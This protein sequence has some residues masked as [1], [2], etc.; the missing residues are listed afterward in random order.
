MINRENALLHEWIGLRARIMK[1]SCR[2]REG[3]M[4]IIVDE[5]RNTLAIEGPDGVVRT[6]PKKSCVFELETGDGPV[7]IM[8][9]EVCYAPEDRPKKLFRKLK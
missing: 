7:R 5:T 9:S 8:G 6:F 2:V 4:G 1:S 3:A